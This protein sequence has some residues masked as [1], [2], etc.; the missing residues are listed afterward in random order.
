MGVNLLTLTDQNFET[1]INQAKLPMVIDFWASWCG[2]CQMLAPVLEEVAGEFTDKV[3]VSKLNVDENR[4]TAGKFGMMSIPTLIF[5]KN[6]KEAKRIT[7]FRPKEELR[8][9]F[10]EALS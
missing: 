5:M 10:Q 1:E 7:G 2:P 4:E 8:K 9:V 3:T 6:G